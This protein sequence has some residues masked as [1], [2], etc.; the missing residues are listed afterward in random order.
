MGMAM[1]AAAQRGIPFVVL[2]RINPIGGEI[3]E[4]NI[5][6]EGLSSFVGLYPI[7]SRHGMTAGELAQMYNTHFGIRADL[8]VVRNEGWTRDLW[9][10]ETD[11]PWTK[12]SPNLPKFEGVIHYPGTVFFEGTNLSEGRG[13]EHPF[14]QTGAPWLRS[15]EVAAAMNARNLPGVRFSAVQ[16]AVLP[17]GRKFGGQTING[18]RLTVTN[19]ETYRPI[20]TTM[21]LIETIRRMHPNEFEW[22]GSMDRLS[23][24]TRIR[25]AIENGTLETL[26]AEWERDAEKFRE[27]R[28]P[29]LLYQ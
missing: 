13:S 24:S 6:E 8:H 25:A 16:F 14:E 18:V 11:L 9:L 19:R 10:D 4:G 27:M 1:Q 3:V 5:R 21:R 7:A 20:A 2:D 23:G 17:T 28:K 29:Y 26:L 15:A 22:R 12:P